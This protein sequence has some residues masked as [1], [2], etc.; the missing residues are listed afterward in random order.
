MIKEIIHDPIFLAG[1]SETATAE[2]LQVAEDLLD[3][4]TANKEKCVGMAA[5]M[6]GVRKAIIVFDNG[7]KNMTMFNPEIIKMSGLYETEEGCL[8]LIGEPRKCKRYKT[9][10]V[11]WQTKDFET[12]IKTF[13]GWTA[14]IIQH[15]IDHCHGIL[16]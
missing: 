15:E 9:I 11:K 3:T 1:K 12:R 2:D 7:G 5:N 10:K 6:I 13:T 16:I 8:S 14:Q 4:L